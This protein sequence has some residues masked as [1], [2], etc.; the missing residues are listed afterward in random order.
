MIRTQELLEF[1]AEKN[2]L[3][4][5]EIVPAA[6]VNKAFER[7]VKNDVKYRFVLDMAGLPQP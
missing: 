5:C 3:P 7:L 2:I 6:D 4:E 1:C